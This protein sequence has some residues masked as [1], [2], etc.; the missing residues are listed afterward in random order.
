MSLSKGFFL[1][2]T[3]IFMAFFSACSSSPE[4]VTK[5]DDAALEINNLKGAPSWVLTGGTG[6]LSAAASAPITQAGLQFARTEAMALARDE[7]ARIIQV[8]VDGLV[9]NAVNQTVAGGVDDA[10]E[11]EKFGEQLTKQ[12]VNEY[13]N[14]T[15]QKDTWIT[16]DGKILFILMNLDSK[17][18]EK[19][20]K[21]VSK[22]AS[23]ASPKISSGDQ[24]RMLE[25]I[26]QAVGEGI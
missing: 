11:V 26:E 24:R 18:G 7:I 3:A 5:I 23:A 22:N 4:G 10:A 19:T 17:L 8:K 14:G 25:A 9:S 21:L 20:R 16:N 2:C 12:L 13:L 15:K 6:E 1:I